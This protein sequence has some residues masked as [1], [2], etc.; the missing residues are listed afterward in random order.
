MSQ[1]KVTKDTFVRPLTE[2]RFVQGVR[3]CVPTLLGY[4]SIGMAA[5]VVQKTAGLSLMD[6]TMLCLILYAGSAQFIAVGMITASSSITA[7]MI[8]VFFVNLRYLLLSAALSPYFKHLTPFRNLLV[9]S[10]VTDET[11]G[12]A[13]NKAIHTHRLSEKW[14]HGL[15]LTAYISWWVANMTGAYVGQWIED[16]ETFG[17]DFALAGMFIGILAVSVISRKRI[18]T[19]VAVGLIAL[20][21]GVSGTFLLSTSLSVIAATL[22]ASTLGV[23]MERWK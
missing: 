7:I 16:P 13:I 20:F 8:T 23:V 15:N 2:D 1:S 10:L 9:G 19:D 17:L 21:V 14:M 5:G 11:F 18:R 3:D 22:V 12:V 6:I 4:F